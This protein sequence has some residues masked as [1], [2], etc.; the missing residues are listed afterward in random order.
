MNFK[1]DSLGEAYISS[2]EKKVIILFDYN[3][4]GVKVKKEVSQSNQQLTFQN[5]YLK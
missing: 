4:T 1:F 3:N 2:A 5:F